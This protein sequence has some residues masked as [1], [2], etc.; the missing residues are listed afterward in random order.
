MS[1]D[2]AVLDAQVAAAKEQITA[3]EAKLAELTATLTE[4][5]PR[6]ETLEKTAEAE[7]AFR[8]GRLAEIERL[9][10]LTERV[11]ELDTLKAAFGADLS[12]MPAEKLLALEADWLK[13]FDA[14]T[15]PGGVRQSTSTD[16]SE[17]TG[18]SIETVMAPNLRHV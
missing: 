4:Q 13:K 17:E 7:K 3:L 15:P 11:T 16:G 14:M 1:E 8:A 2:T 5:T 9:A 18:E 6:L 10:G 12:A